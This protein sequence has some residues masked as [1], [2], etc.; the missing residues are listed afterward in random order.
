MKLQ[1][2]WKKKIYQIEYENK[3]ENLIKNLDNFIDNMKNE[4]LDL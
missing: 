2:N 4:P 1:K 3:A